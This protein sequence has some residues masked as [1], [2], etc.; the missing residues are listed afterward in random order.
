M[1]GGNCRRTFQRGEPSGQSRPL[2]DD[3][4]RSVMERTVDLRPDIHAKGPEVRFHTLASPAH[5]AV[6]PIGVPNLQRP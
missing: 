4:A 2:P 6:L 1:Q 3:Q 5:N